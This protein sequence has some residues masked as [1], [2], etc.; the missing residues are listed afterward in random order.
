MMNASWQHKNG[1]RILQDPVIRSKAQEH[2][3]KC[4]LSWHCFVKIK[5]KKSALVWNAIK[6]LNAWRIHI[7][8]S[9]KLH[10]CHLGYFSSSDTIEIWV[11]WTHTREGLNHRPIFRALLC[12]TE[13]PDNNRQGQRDED[14]RQQSRLRRRLLL[15]LSWALGGE[16]KMEIWQRWERKIEGGGGRQMRWSLVW[17]LKA[18]QKWKW[19]WIKFKAAAKW[20]TISHNKGTTDSVWARMG[21]NSFYWRLAR[22]PRNACL[23]TMHAGLWEMWS[24]LS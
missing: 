23:A 2:A 22:Q 13:D 8:H 10:K 3:G 5:I 20:G 7:L 6:N 14:W 16:R 18:V 17:S 11:Q 19:K 4:I 9:S 21:A 24:Q 15:Y 1:K 12:V